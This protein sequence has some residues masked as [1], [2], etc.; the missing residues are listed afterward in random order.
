MDRNTSSGSENS[1][2]VCSGLVG[3]DRNWF[4][5]YAP[6]T[7]W[8]LK[9][10]GV[11]EITKDGEMLALSLPLMPRFVRVWMKFAFALTCSLDPTNCVRLAPGPCLPNPLP[12][13]TPLPLRF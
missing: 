10:L 2:K 5:G 13:M 7:G 8:K 1:A 11:A 6:F 9:K 3:G 4:L 12:Y